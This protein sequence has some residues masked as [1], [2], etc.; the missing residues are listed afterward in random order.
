[1][2]E[3]CQWMNIDKLRTSA[4]KPSTNGMVER[5]HRTLN[6]MLGKCVSTNQR[7]W[8][9]RLQTVV[10]AY[11]ASRHEATGF[12]PNMLMM[13]REARAPLD[14]VLGAPAEECDDW[15]SYDGWVADDKK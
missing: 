14:V 3:L 12:S 13:G 10:A 8:D 15:Y 6:S 7:D 5:F 2:K 4:Y 9:E 1:M 11:R